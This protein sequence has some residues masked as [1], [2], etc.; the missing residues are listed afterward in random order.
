MTDPREARLPKWAQEEMRTLRR[1]L[2]I[3]RRVNA[4]LR[5]EIPETNTWVLDYGRASQP[6]PNNARVSFHLRHDDGRIRRS[7][8][9]Y[10]EYGHL[11][12]Q[13]DD[14]LSIHP[15]A[16]NSFTINFRER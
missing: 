7:I 13:G 10:V 12:I 14:T 2:D 8:Q 5:G 4:D 16:S 9:A 1:D 11:R 3:E 15:G 6:L